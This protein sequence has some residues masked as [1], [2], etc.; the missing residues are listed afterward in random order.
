MEH[1]DVGL[2]HQLNKVNPDELNFLDII[3]PY[4]SYTYAHM[5]TNYKAFVEH[6][7]LMQCHIVYT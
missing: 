3:E 1:V 4:I 2:G 5:P 6:A 7:T